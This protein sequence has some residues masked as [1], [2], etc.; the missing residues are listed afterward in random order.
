MG[1]RQIKYKVTMCFIDQR[2]CKFSPFER[3][4]RA[5]EKHIKKNHTQWVRMHERWKTTPEMIEAKEREKQG[6][7]AK[8][9]GGEGDGRSELVSA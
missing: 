1:Q 3:F 7:K 6:V 9:E 2:L 8:K 5:A 4:H